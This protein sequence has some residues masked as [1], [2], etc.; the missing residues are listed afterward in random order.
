M[1]HFMIDYIEIE[2]I[3]DFGSAETYDIWNYDEECQ[4]SFGGNFSIDGVIVHNS[5]PEAIANRDDETG[6]W[7]E[8][9]KRTHPAFYDILKDTYGIILYQEQL[10]ALWQQLAGFTSPEAQD[11]RK[12]VAKKWTFKL[13][14]I[15]KKWLEGASKTIGIQ[16]AKEWWDKM[17][18]FGRYAFNRCLDGRTPLT[19]LET[20]ETKTVEEWYHSPTKPTLWSY[21]GEVVKDKC[22]DIHYSGYQEVFEITF[23][24]GSTEMVTMKHKFLCSDGNYHEVREIIDKGLDVIKVNVERHTPAEVEE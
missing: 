18:T 6:A 20:G 5:I 14:P 13:K 12:A 8:R 21:N 4:D 10:A 22:L 17:V 1:V 2:S 3:T 16:A 11:A 19:D 9:L 7:K 15:E 23:D 24:D